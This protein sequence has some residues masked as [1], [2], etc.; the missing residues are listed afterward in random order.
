VCEAELRGIEFVLTAPDA[1]ATG[2]PP[3]P[4]AKPKR[5]D[6]RALV[7]EYMRVNSLDLDKARTQHRWIAQYLDCRP[8]QV[9]AALTALDKGEKAPSP[10]EQS[11]Q[12]EEVEEGQE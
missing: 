2:P 10:A 7:R 9:K 1:P 3:E 6:I 12:I 11:G 5:R 8:S 4:D